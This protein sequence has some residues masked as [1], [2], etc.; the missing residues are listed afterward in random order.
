MHHAVDQPRLYPFLL[1][2]PQLRIRTYVLFLFFKKIK[3]FMAFLTRVTV[4]LAVALTGAVTT[5][6]KL[7]AGRPRPDLI[8]RCLPRSGSQN[9]AVFGLV[10][11]S[12][13]TQTDFNILNDGWKSFASGHSS[14]TSPALSGSI[15]FCLMTDDIQ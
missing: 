2:L 12:I 3:I 9:A 5:I 15:A 8:A 10:D 14:R 1:G 11:Q 4:T 7:T 6:L 13:C